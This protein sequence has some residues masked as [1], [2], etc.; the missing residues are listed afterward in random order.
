MAVSSDR[1]R[2]GGRLPRGPHGLDPG[3]VVADQRRRLVDAMVQLAG[4]GGF[5]ATTVAGLIEHAGVSRKTFYALYPSREALLQDAFEAC[6]TS[7]FS[8][9]KTASERT[10]GPTRQLESAIKRL[11]RVAGE[12]PGAI[13]LSGFEIAAMNPSGLK[14]REQ[15]MSRYGELIQHC[16]ATDGGALFP[17]RLATTLAGAIHRAID[18]HL[19]C[20]RPEELSE[21][22]PQLARFARSHHPLPE[23]FELDDTEPPAGPWPWIGQDGLVGGRAPGTLTLAPHGHQDPI[24]KP[25]PG[26]RAHANRERILDAVAQLTAEHG[27]PALSAEAI[28]ERADLPERAFLA[29]FK[30]RDDAFAAAVELGHVKGQAIVERARAGVP[31]WPTGV[32]HAVHGL[33]EFFASEP[34]FTHMAL[35]DAPLAGSAMGRRLQEHVGAYARLMLDGAPQRRKPAPIAAQAVIHSLFELAYRHAAS[36]TTPQLL[37]AEREAAYLALAPFLGVTE[38]ARV[39]GERSRPSTESRPKR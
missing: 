19:R 6:A 39:A 31:D 16:L 32:R 30:S 10:G 8:D 2:S 33:L 37:R 17:R 24:A 36:H 23:G 13:A 21:L 11:C 26:F 7:T 22:A 38:A 28:A 29:H 14:L 27:Y 35:I 3:D 9:V 5:A 1:N 4:T 25:S 18:A 15:L 34:P 12:R 20:Q